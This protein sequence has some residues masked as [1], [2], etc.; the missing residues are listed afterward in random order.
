MPISIEHIGQAK[1][2]VALAVFPHCTLDIQR[3][4]M[5]RGMKKSVELLTRK[6]AA[7]ITRIKN[8]LPPFPLETP[9]SK[10]SDQEL[11]GLLEWSL[12]AAWRKKFD[13]DGIS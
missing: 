7:D 2:L 1:D 11:V 10:F 13:L 12:L 4:W 9:D 6:T 5:N 3:L 8:S